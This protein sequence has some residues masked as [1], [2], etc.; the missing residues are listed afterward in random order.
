MSSNDFPVGS[1]E[2]RRE[3]IKEIA[4]QIVTS[5][6]AKG[7][8]NVDDDAELERAMKEAGRTAKEAYD[9]AIEFTAG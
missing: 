8:V 2:H 4:I 9:A 7:E 1:P 3:R 6:A 5:Q